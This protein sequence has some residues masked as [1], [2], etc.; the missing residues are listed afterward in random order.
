MTRNPPRPPRLVR[1]DGEAYPQP[2][3]ARR[4]R[5]PPGNFVGIIGPMLQREREAREPADKPKE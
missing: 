1:L 2:P 3:V 4:K 5:K